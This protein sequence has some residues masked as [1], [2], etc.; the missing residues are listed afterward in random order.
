V[1]HAKTLHQSAIHSAMPGRRR[2]KEREEEGNP[3][4]NITGLQRPWKTYSL[5]TVTSKSYGPFW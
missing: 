4:R 2:Q 5:Q 3:R 1:H